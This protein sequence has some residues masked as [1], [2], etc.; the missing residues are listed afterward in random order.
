MAPDVHPWH[1][2]R[3]ILR[4][5]LPLHTQPPPAHPGCTYPNPVRAPHAPAP[6][7]SLRTRRAW[8]RSSSPRT[9]QEIRAAP[10]HRK[11]DSARDSDEWGDQREGQSYSS[12]DTDPECGRFKV[13]SAGKTQELRMHRGQHIHQVD[14]VS[15]QATVISG[16]KQRYQIEPHRC[17]T[18]NRE[19]E[20]IVR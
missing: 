13:I 3:P 6:S 20:V 9:I 17:R 2:Q 5:S 14:A 19:F 10:F 16:W 7:N 18:S 11:I 1:V 8:A 12:I 4:L 15:I